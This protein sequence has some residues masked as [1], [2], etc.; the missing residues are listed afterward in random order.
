MVKNQMKTMKKGFTIIEIVI[1]IA[2]IGAMMAIFGNKLFGFFEKADM[3]TTLNNDVDMVFQG[4]TN[5]KNSSP[6]SNNRFDNLTSTELSKYV[7]DKMILNNGKLDSLGLAQ[8]CNYTVESTDEDGDS[9]FTEYKVLVDC[10]AASSDLSWTSQSIG[11]MQDIIERAFNDRTNSA[12]AEATDKTC[13]SGATVDNTVA[14]I[15]L[16]NIK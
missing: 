8:G 6:K 16:I 15:C 4:I 11:R 9:K 5:Y 14:E 3:Q 2:I 1:V 13:T 10:T 12:N 7:S